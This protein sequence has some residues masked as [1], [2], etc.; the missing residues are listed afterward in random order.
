MDTKRKG[1]TLVELLVVIGIIGILLAIVIPVYGRAK[2]RARQTQCQSYLHSIAMAIRM[3]RDDWG[4]YPSVAMRDP[5][6]AGSPSAPT[7]PTSKS[8][9]GGIVS[10]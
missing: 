5:T 4:A 8:N 2:E 6:L 1:F 9:L 3:Y 7:D 10:L